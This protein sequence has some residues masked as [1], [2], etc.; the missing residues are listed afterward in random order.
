MDK[1]ALVIP[2]SSRGAG[3]QHQGGA[4]LSGLASG[5]AS[6]WTASQASSN[7]GQVRRW[8]R[9]SSC[10]IARLL[11]HWTRRIIWRHDD[12]DMLIVDV[13]ALA[14]GTALQ[15]FLD[16]VLVELAWI[17]ADAQDVLGIQGAVGDQLS[18]PVG[19]HPLVHP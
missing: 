14:D 6:V 15:N 19:N 5:D 12:L 17:A 10:G 7:Y 16:Q 1:A 13:N 9:S 4:I 2:S 8:S 11:P 18:H 3:G